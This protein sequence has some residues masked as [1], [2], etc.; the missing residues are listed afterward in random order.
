MFG[1]LRFIRGFFG[2]IAAWQVLGLLPVLSWLQDPA[3]V[4]GNMMAMLVVK[5]LM[6]VLSVGAF[7]GLRALINKLHIKRHGIKHP[8]LE[9]KWA[10]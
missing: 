8:S 7:F 3:S 9:K 4:N 1:L 6:M 10:L 5:L 2:F